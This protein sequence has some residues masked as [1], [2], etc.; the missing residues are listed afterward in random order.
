MALVTVSVK[1]QLAVVLAERV[2]GWTVAPGR[3]LTGKRG[4]I[5][6]WRFQPE[7]NLNDAFRLLEGAKPDAYEMGSKKGGKFWVR[8]AIAGVVG[9]ACEG[10]KPRAITSAIAQA[11]GIDVEAEG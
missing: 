9:E 11:L 6:L 5:P 2:L 1:G 7:Q 3:F 4:W 10:S 8:V